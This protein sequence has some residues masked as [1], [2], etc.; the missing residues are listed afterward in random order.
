MNR[1]LG[2]L[3]CAL[4]V[5]A[6]PVAAQRSL[7]IDRFDSK[8]AI[9]PDGRLDITE[10]ITATFTGSWNGI[11]RKVPLDYR[12]G[13]GF[14][15]SIRV[16]FLGAADE[17]GAPLRAEQER[18]AHYLKLK[19]WIPGA[20]DA[21]KTVVL[22]YRASNALRFFD[23][24][25]E[26]YWNATG[27]EWDVALGMV[28]AEVTL[29]DGATGIRTSAFNGVYGSTAKEAQ[30]TTEGRRVTFVMPRKLEFR[31]GLTVVVGWD[32]GLV[33]AP[34]ALDKIL[35]F[36]NDNWPVAIPIPVFLLMFFLWSTRGKDPSRLPIVAQYEPPK[37]MT[38]AEAGTITDESVDMRDITAT[39]VDLAVRGYLRIE[40]Q[41]SAKVLGLFGGSTDYS[42]VRTKPPASWS[43][44]ATHEQRV[45]GGIFHGGAE[46][47]DLSDLTNEFYE[48]LPG[49]KSAVMGQLVSKGYYLA[50]P[51]LVR[52]V[53]K[54]GGVVAGIVIGF[55]GSVLGV[56][57]GLTP[58][59]FIVGG[60]LTGLIVLVF[61][62]LMPARTIPGT[63]AL[64][65]TLGYGEFLRRVDSDRFAR[66]VKTPEMFEQGLSYAMALGVERQWSKAF[67]DIYRTPPN[68]YRGSSMNGFNAMMFSSHLSSMTHQA[69]S[70]MSSQPRSSS[71]SGF[72]G[73][74]SSG[75][76]GGGG[77][78]GGF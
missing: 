29:P 52:N 18:E 5:A 66:V 63:R 41:E 1:H 2:A 49:I 64:E 68:W 24:H 33:A 44:L 22:H 69:S 71:G 45:L 65:A 42:F 37:G 6:T 30:I 72:S 47:V 59:P 11:Y 32:K 28:S 3:L 14:N 56:K 34:T 10:T 75:G 27:D 73:G 15:W 67:A 43:A 55:L 62:H 50:R 77:G 26:L 76:G 21:T 9:L 16:E 35:A 36:F 13:Q 38:P 54:G 57:L 48:E 61:G 51:D 31:E 58:V 70:A 53:W 23:D 17:E 78:G 20:N 39:L 12:T 7:V 25:D 40:E 60:V 8:I 74:G 4:V 46:R 19:M